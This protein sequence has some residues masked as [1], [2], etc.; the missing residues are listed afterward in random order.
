[1]PFSDFL[2][3]I[4]NCIKKYANIDEFTLNIFSEG[5]DAWK[6]NRRSMQDYAVLRDDYAFVFHDVMESYIEA[7]SL[8][9]ECKLQKSVL[10]PASV[11]VAHSCYPK[12]LRRW[13]NGTISRKQKCRVELCTLIY[14]WYDVW[15]KEISPKINMKAFTKDLLDLCGNYIDSKEYS[16]IYLDKDMIWQA[17]EGAYRKALKK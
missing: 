1:M 14:C 10:I 8:N 4:Y 3:D 6:E 2:N 13:M 16:N 5:P 11:K 17:C 7:Y 15:L 12:N 9:I